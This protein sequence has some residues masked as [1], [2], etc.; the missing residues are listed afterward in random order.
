MNI[1]SLTARQIRCSVGRRL[2]GCSVVGAGAGWTR[3]QQLHLAHVGAGCGAMALH[4]NPRGRSCLV[5]CMRCFAGSATPLRGE[6]VTLDR[7]YPGL[8][9]CST[10]SSRSST[11]H[12]DTLHQGHTTGLYWPDRRRGCTS[13]DSGS[14]LRSDTWRQRVNGL[15]ASAPEGDAAM[16]HR[17][18]P[19]TDRCG[20][21]RPACA[22]PTPARRS[23]AMRRGGA[24]LLALLL[25]AL[26]LACSFSPTTVVG[27]A[28][29]AAI[30][31]SFNPA[32]SDAAT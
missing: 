17:A 10:P 4:M 14:S 16:P 7:P 9:R 13:L 27:R 24:V 32:K 3:T 23:S 30:T 19:R 26:L 11:A 2:S 29:H 21:P 5:R 31:Y 15:G 20:H 12:A 25:G 8:S 22:D 6:T 1:E 28:G 18:R